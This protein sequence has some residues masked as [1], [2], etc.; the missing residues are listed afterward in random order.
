MQSV[1][2]APNPT[3]RRIARR[4]LLR[5]AAL[6]GVAVAGGCVPGAPDGEGGSGGPTG[7]DAAHSVRL[8]WEAPSTDAEGGPLSDLAGFRIHFAPGDDPAGPGTDVVEAG[9]G[10][11]AL[12]TNLPSGTWTFAV[13]AVD[14]AGNESALSAPL[15]VR[16]GEP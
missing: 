10:T 15:T 2:G 1:P 6:G 13:A 12:V 8:A 7:P 16:V 9:T 4:A 14:T 3:A 5:A 11:A